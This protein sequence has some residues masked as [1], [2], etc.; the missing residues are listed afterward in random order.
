MDF[1]IIK[2][3]PYVILLTIASFLF[4]VIVCMPTPWTMSIT[5]IFEYYIVFWVYQEYTNKA[6]KFSLVGVCKRKG[7]WALGIFLG[8]LISNYIYYGKVT[9]TMC[10]AYAV[11]V[12]VAF[13]LL[14]HSLYD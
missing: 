4:N 12:I 5:W 3:T 6:D 14:E 8:A 11:M 1:K 7:L 2:N 13:T 9:K 10:A